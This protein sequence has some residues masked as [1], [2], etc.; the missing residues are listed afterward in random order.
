M[1]IDIDLRRLR[2]FVEV[3]RQGRFSQAAKASAMQPTVSK[4]PKAALDLGGHGLGYHISGVR[5]VLVG[6]DLAPVKMH[7]AILFP[8]D[9]AFPTSRQRP[10]LPPAIYGRVIFLNLVYEEVPIRRATE[11]EYST[12]DDYGLSFDVG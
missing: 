5:L 2:F 6:R 3:V 9:S 8:Y 7:D 1:R 4:A 11:H 10:Q 12:A